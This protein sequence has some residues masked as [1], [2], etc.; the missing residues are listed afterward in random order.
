MIA[1]GVSGAPQHI[2]WV[3]DRAVIF[4]FN[5]DPH[6][7]LMTLN[8]RRQ[9]PRV[10]PVVGDLMKTVPKFIAALRKEKK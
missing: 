9:Q 2:D 3:A 6:A 10:V 7:P 5:L 8:Q 1:L 4:S